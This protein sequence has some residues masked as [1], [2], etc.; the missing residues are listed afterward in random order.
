[1]TMSDM[2]GTHR[3]PTPGA[4]EDA[5]G[6]ARPRVSILMIAYNVAPYIG[7]AI[8]SVLM[9]RVNFRYQLVIGEDCSTD[10]TR[11][12][13]ADY[14]RRHP[15]RIRAIL[16]DRNMGM[17]ENFVA[18][19]AQ[20]DGEYVA[21]LD[22]DDLWTSPD[23]LQQQ[24]DLMDRE[25]DCAMCVHNA[26]VTY[27]DESESPHPFY[28]P[29]RWNRF[30][31]PTPKPRSSIADLATGNFIQTGSVLYR[32]GLVSTLPDWFL[33]MPTFDWPLHVL[34][35]EHGSI[36][37]IDEVMSTYRVRAGSFWSTGMSL[38]RRPEE[39]QA[40][41][42]AYETL[43][44]YLGFRYEQQIRQRIVALYVR[45]AEVLLASGDRA[46]ARRYARRVM[47]SRF[48]RLDSR[49]RAAAKVWLKALVGR[50]RKGH[51]DA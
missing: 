13:V 3:S 51:V 28:A 12:I 20:C 45:A 9:Q 23:K 36:A 46:G 48:P 41:I 18:T 2:A 47:A 26:L 35:A 32:G 21:L 27:E 37:Y 34:H 40:M 33:G 5:A 24:V 10:A 30:T 6:S 22:G 39:V 25:R 50:S 4:G 44:R 49:G 19:Y 31:S 1:M 11:D 38:Y 43:N 8:E 17:N 14:A 42:T 16:R 7:E 15:D 29:Q